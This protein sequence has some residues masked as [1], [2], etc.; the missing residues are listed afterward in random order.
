MKTVQAVGLLAAGKIRDSFLRGLPQLAEKLGPVRSS[1]LRLASRICGILGAG[2][3]ADSFGDFDQCQLVLISMPEAWLPAAVDELL[4]ASVD[5]KTKTVLLCD[6]ELESSAIQK[7]SFVGAATGSITPVDGFDDSLFVVEGDRKAV[8][9]A[10]LLVE[11]PE[12]RVVTIESGQK[13]QYVAGLSFA[14]TL[15]LPLVTACVETLRASGLDPNISTLVA[16]RLFIRSLRS[17]LKA[18]RKGWE[19]AVAEQD[20]EKVRRHVQALFRVNPL[21]ASYYYE[22]A[23]LVVQMMRQDPAWLTKLANELYPR[24]ASL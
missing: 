4:E 13:A 19:G 15:V 3:P 1:S 10:R 11:R 5:W 17:Y 20:A 16:E 9:E 23:H 12:V 24:A 8:R 14:T 7:L 2:K 6:A 22:N 18:G 21:L